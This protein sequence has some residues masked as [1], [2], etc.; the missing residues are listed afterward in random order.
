MDGSL[1]DCGR[2]ICHHPRL[3]PSSSLSMAHA[4]SPTHSRES[5]GSSPNPLS[6]GGAARSSSSPGVDTFSSPIDP[7]LDVRR[8]IA[9]L[10]YLLSHTKVEG[11]KSSAEAKALETLDP[12]TYL[13]WIINTGEAPYDK[14]GNKVIAVTGRI[15]RE[16]I[17]AAFVARNTSPDRLPA[18]TPPL[19]TISLKPQDPEEGESMLRQAIRSSQYVVLKCV[20]Y[21]TTK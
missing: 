8:D 13:A 6:S 15:D 18:N 2:L 9:L 19:Q 16:G 4:T 14:P 11:W 17:T 20:A 21:T 10:S 7:E 3:R 12:W 1:R 5:S